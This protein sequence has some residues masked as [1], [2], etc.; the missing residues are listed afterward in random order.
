MI[1]L[2]EKQAETMKESLMKLNDCE[3]LMAEIEKDLSGWLERYYDE[4]YNSV[5]G[6]ETILNKVRTWM[7]ASKQGE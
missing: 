4:G 3:E 7:S 1:E 2:T 6:L 5:Y